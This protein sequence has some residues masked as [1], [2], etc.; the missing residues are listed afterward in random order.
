MSSS[1]S[2]SRSS[3]MVRFRNFDLEQTLKLVLHHPTPPPLS[4]DKSSLLQF[5]GLYMNFHK[6]IW[7]KPWNNW[8]MEGVGGIWHPSPTP[9]SP[10]KTFVG[11]SNQKSDCVCV[12]IKKYQLLPLNILRSTCSKIILGGGEGCQ[13]PTPSLSQ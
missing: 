12:A 11:L 5:K 1:G 6:F 8:K 9:L 7:V 13:I 3:H 2:G 4:Q 10:H